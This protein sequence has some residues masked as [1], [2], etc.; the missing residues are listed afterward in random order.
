MPEENTQEAPVEAPVENTETIDAAAPVEDPVTAD[1]LWS[2]ETPVIEEEAKPDEGIPPAEAPAASEE[3]P[4]QGGTPAEEVEEA[5]DFKLNRKELREIDKDF[6][7]PFRN[8]DIP[9]TQA[10][11]A[12]AS[13]WPKRAEALAQEI[14]DTSIAK[15][16]DQW[17]SALLGTEITVD[18][19]KERLNSEPQ[20]S[21]IATPNEG[22]ARSI[23][24]LT[25]EYGESW[26]DPANDENIADPS[27]RAAIQGFRTQLATIE[28]SEAGKSALQ[29]ELTGL[30]SRFET[31]EKTQEVEFQNKITAT[32]QTFSSE[33]REKIESG[34][35]QKLLTDKSLVVSENDTPEVKGVKELVQSQ[36]KPYHDMASNFDIF[37]M[38]EFTDRESFAKIIKRTDANLAEAAASSLKAQRAEND[39][40]RQRFEREVTAYKAEADREQDSLQVFYH[41]AAS[42]FLE[43]TNAPIMKLL[44]QNAN[45]MRQLA[46]N[47]ERMEIVG[48]GV[49]PLANGNNGWSDKIASAKSAEDLWA[50]DP[51]EEI[52]GKVAA[53]Q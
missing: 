26:R 42:E 24:V 36:F 30:R 44:E 46:A 25:D 17:M 43:T 11:E 52:R 7:S 9:I 51:G 32:H 45:L 39:A 20:P 8:P 10:Y 4:A 19:V 29:E 31:I 37:V 22:I 2:S 18:K 6:L 1:S 33:Y 40:D 47:G 13:R 38:K 23:Q 49:A 53:A 28:A 16:P 5:Y 41:K 48:G 12:L 35:L 27:E 34:G 14:L 3:I 15:H 50:L 21:T